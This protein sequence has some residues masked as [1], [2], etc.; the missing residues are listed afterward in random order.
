MIAKLFLKMIGNTSINFQQTNWHFLISYTKIIYLFFC[1]SKF[2]LSG[3]FALMTK[4]TLV[5]RAARPLSPLGSRKTNIRRRKEERLPKHHLSSQG[6]SL[7]FFLSL[8]KW[9]VQPWRWW[10]AFWDPR[11]R[12][13]LPYS[14]K[15]SHQSHPILIADPSPHFPTALSI[16]AAIPRTGTSSGSFSAAPASARAPTPPASP[17]SSASPTSPP[18]ILSARSSRPPVPSLRRWIRVSVSFLVS[19]ISFYVIMFRLCVEK[20]RSGTLGWFWIDWSYWLRIWAQGCAW[21]LENVKEGNYFWL[22]FTWL[23]YYFFL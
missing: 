12:H 6:K 13:P 15:P 23:V 16:S 21:V 18:A 10:T 1:V 2:V 11:L 17:L 7:S 4:I 19:W 8:S 5:C 9:I 3:S 14:P 20:L 22:T